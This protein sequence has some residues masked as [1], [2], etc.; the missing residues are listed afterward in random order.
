M[1][2]AS[3]PTTGA[4][5]ARSRPLPWGRPSTMSTSTTSAR[6]ASAMRCAVV[7]PTLPAPMTVTLS[8]AMPRSSS[9]L[10]GAA[11]GHLTDIVGAD[12]TRVAHGLAHAVRVGLEVLVEHVGDL[13]GRQVV[14]SRIR[15]R[16]ARLEDLAGDAR[17]LGRDGHAEYGIEHGRHAGEAAVEGSPDHV[18]GVDDV[19]PLADAVRPAGPAGIHEPDGD[20]EPVEAIHEQLRVHA[21]VA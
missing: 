17:H 12:R 2:R 5:S 14:C 15:P 21:R 10:A 16:R 13:A 7:A 8:R 19:H 20:V 11:D 9:A 4:A 6:P 1:R 18:P 3:W